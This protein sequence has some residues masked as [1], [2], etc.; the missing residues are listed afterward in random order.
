M[1]APAQHYS[2][3]AIVS[4]TYTELRLGSSKV[5]ICM[6]NL[7]ARPVTIPARMTIGSVN[8][9]NAVPPILAP[10]IKTNEDNQEKGP[11]VSKAKLSE[12]NWKNCFQN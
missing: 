11:D 4:L 6:K 7:S 2:E 3:Q 10:K 9:T 1:E 12:E 8:T 5:A